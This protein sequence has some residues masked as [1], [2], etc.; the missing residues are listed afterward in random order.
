VFGSQR[1]EGPQRARSTKLAQEVRSAT[2]LFALFVP[3]AC[4]WSKYL[5]NAKV[6]DEVR[7][8]DHESTKAREEREARRARSDG[9]M[10]W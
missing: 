7:R 2:N 5:F 3:F 1:D 9:C 4:S 6:L 8:L 10:G